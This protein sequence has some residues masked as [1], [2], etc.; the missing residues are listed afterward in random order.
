MKMFNME[1]I[2]D[3]IYFFNAEWCGPCKVVK[4]YLTEDVMQEYNITSVDISVYPE[5]A[6]KHFVSS[7]PTFVKIVKGTKEKMYTGRLSLNELKNF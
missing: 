4:K 7:V 6:A 1:D 5:L 2:Q 3:G